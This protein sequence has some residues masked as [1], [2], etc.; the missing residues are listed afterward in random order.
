MMPK[1]PKILRN[2]HLIIAMT[3]EIKITI[4]KQ[5]AKV[6]LSFFFVTKVPPLT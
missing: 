2:V 6:P 1:I 4:P 5:P 3:K